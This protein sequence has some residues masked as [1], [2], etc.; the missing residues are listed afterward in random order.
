MFLF[1]QQVHVL[2]REVFGRS[3]FDL[4][5]LMMKC[6]PI[7]LVDKILVVTARLVLGNI[8]K[9]GL[10]RPSVGSLQLKNSEGKTRVGHWCFAK[11]QIW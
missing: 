8:E 11:N 1:I 2:P 5:V 4:A 10:R 6:L 7:W 9:Y 3:T